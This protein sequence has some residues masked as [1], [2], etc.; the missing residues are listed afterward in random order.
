LALFLN[1][2]M[3]HLLGDF[4][5][6]PGR[7]VTAK[8]DGALGLLLHVTIVGAS[9]ALVLVGTIAYHWPIL[10]LVCG[11]HIVIEEITILAY[12]RTPTRPL[13]T[14]VLDQSLHVLSMALLVWLW[15]EW[16]VN[17]SAVSFGI[18]MTT[19]QLAALCALGT[20]TLFGSVFVFEVGNTV[21]VGNEAK[22]RLLRFDRAR[23][24]GMVERGVAI[25]AGLVVNPLLMIVPFVPRVV[26]AL[27]R[28]SGQDRRRNVIEAIAGL[29]ICALCYVA[30]I[31]IAL[32][33][34]GVP[35]SAGTWSMPT[36]L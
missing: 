23:V 11:M 36:V 19:V 8:R 35:G 26:W 6:Q 20:A 2:Y 15:G 21:L 9:T 34:G 3:G 12:M 14:F 32:L 18:P 22:G 10:V 16:E 33:V 5:F 7:L 27:A 30:V 29:G 13:Y 1:L 4:L 17:A 31:V 25:A 28:T 24:G